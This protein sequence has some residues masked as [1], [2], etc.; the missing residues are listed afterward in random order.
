M[1]QLQ[2]PK[3]IVKARIELRKN[4]KIEYECPFCFTEYKLNGNPR[5]N[6]KHKFHTV[7]NE[8]DI[9]IMCDSNRFPQGI[10]SG[11]VIKFF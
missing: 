1:D 11:V 2:L 4:G 3:L 5:K 10:Y 7:N 6:A 9:D 8:F